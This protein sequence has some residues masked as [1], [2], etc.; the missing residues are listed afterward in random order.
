MWRGEEGGGGRSCRPPR[1]LM[2]KWYGSTSYSCT[3][4]SAWS[5]MLSLPKAG[6]ATLSSDGRKSG[7]SRWGI[8]QE[9]GAGGR[10]DSRIAPLSH[11]GRRWSKEST[12]TSGARRTGSDQRTAGGRGKTYAGNARAVGIGVGGRQCWLW[13]EGA[14]FSGTPRKVARA[15][16]KRGCDRANGQTA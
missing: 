7:G 10:S 6:A 2:E 11:P 14:G 9:D 3:L 15:S 13:F 1:S 4:V 8:G 16:D 12:A 5:A